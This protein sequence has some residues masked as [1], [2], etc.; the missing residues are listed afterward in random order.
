MVAIIHHEL[1]INATTHYHCYIN[2]WQT[3]VVL[4]EDI[5]SQQAA[6]HCLVCLHEFSVFVRQLLSDMFDFA[7]YRGVIPYTQ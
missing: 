2:K 6:W 1:L 5:V 3:S 4:H 7:D